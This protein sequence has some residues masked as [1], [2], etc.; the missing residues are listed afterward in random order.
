MAEGIAFHMRSAIA[1]LLITLGSAIAQEAPPRA[2]AATN[3]EP[4]VRRAT[5]ANPA[6][7]NEPEVRRAVP[8]DATGTAG[9]QVRRAVAVSPVATPA[10]AN[11]AAPAS[12]PTPRI[13]TGTTQ[14]A[15]TESPRSVYSNASPATSPNTIPGRPAEGGAERSG[16]ALQ[17]KPTDTVVAVA[18]GVVFVIALFTTI[19]LAICLK[20][21]IFIFLNKWDIALSLMMPVILILELVATTKRDQFW[22]LLFWAIFAAAIIG[23]LFTGWKSTGSIVLALLLFIPKIIVIYASIIFAALSALFAVSAAQFLSMKEK[24]GRKYAVLAAGLSAGSGMGS[25]KIKNLIDRLTRY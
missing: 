6:G 21:G 11:S 24:E 3:T 5:A 2:T 14:R 25:Y 13:Q 17:H 19:M 16:Q 9:I 15:P 1:V 20:K 22:V 18:W 8:V 12:Q 10:V 23:S 7:P 4:E